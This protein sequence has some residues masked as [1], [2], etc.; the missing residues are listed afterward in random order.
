MVPA[1]FEKSVLPTGHYVVSLFSAAYVASAY[2]SRPAS[3]NND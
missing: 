2:V 1:I 3:F